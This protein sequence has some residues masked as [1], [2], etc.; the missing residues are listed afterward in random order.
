MILGV[1]VKVINFVGSK[2]IMYNNNKCMYVC[3]YMFINKY[4][5]YKK[6]KTKYDLCGCTGY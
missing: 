2:S 1:E 4:M 5:Q 3:I 6:K